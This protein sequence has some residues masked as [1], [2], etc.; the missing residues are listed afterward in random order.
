MSVKRL[1]LWLVILLFVA[2]ITL[3]LLM[4]QQI[5]KLEKQDYGLVDITSMP[6]GIYEGNASAVL[7]TARVE[8]SIQD[9]H[10]Q[11]VKLLEHQHGSG[12]GAQAL[13]DSIVEANNL[14]VDSISGATLSSTVVKAAVLDALKSK[15]TQ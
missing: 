5:K 3:F 13:C 12:H 14:D 7:V 6:D 15:A 2:G 11:Q 10:I 9:G 4:G 8:V 1:L